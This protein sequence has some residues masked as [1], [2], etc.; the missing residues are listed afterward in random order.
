[1]KKAPVR[2]ATTAKPARKTP[3]KQA[4][5]TRT[6]A[7]KPTR[8]AAPPGKPVVAAE[9]ADRP[10]AA[11]ARPKP[12]ETARPARTRDGKKGPAE[13]EA[14]GTSTATGPA[15]KGKAE[16]AATLVPPRKP[17]RR[18]RPR[19]DED[20]VED[21]Q[22]E[23]ESYDEGEDDGLEMFDEDG[24]SFGLAPSI[25]LVRRRKKKKKARPG[26]AGKK[27]RRLKLKR[28]RRSGR[29]RPSPPLQKTDPL[30]AYLAGEMVP[31]P[32]GC[33]GFS[34]VVR[35]GSLESRAGEVWFECLSCAQRR[36]FEIP[37]ATKAENAAV[38][39]T[40]E[41]DGREPVCPRHQ[42]PVQLRR[43]GRQFVCP[44][45]GVVFL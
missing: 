21:D 34:E 43:R 36:A 9:V 41:T 31:C 14:S 32:V 16:R 44:A 2:K 24:E 6:P 37:K 27:G 25:P 4:A 1:M 5:A 28:R 8:P 23:D 18:R 42:R 38:S 33:G 11:R 19:F 3:V 26:A 17:G 30:G 22:G 39:E 29:V 13:V 7:A 20:D 15:P 40:A 10:K 45:C 12:D 35:V